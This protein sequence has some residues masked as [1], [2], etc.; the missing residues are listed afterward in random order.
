MKREGNASPW[1]L[2]VPS[3]PPALE[4][5]MVLHQEFQVYHIKGIRTFD[6]QMKNLNHLFSAI[7]IIF[8]LKLQICELKNLDCVFLL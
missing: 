3:G 7:M 1:L 5:S 8:L 2:G 4:I 6:I